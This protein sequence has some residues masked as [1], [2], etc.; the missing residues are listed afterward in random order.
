MDGG[1]DGNRPMRTPVKRPHH[2]EAPHAEVEQTASPPGDAGKR[3]RSSA[4]YE[5]DADA[6]PGLGLRVT[7]LRALCGFPGDAVLTRLGR[8]AGAVRVYA[9]ATHRRGAA[10]GCGG[11]R[12]GH[13]RVGAGGRQ[14]AGGG[15][16]ACRPHALHASTPRRCALAPLPAF[17]LC[18]CCSQHIP[19]AS[20][21]ASHERGERCLCEPNAGL[22]ASEPLS[23]SE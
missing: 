12:G 16:G 21:V 7:R 3:V 20:R 14:A 23:S 11:G 2:D 6:K 4:S 10:Y 17:Y 13:R 8:G 9:A 1:V 22:A 5:C 15:G 19:G 18:T